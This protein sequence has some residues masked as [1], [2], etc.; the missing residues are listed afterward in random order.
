MSISDTSQ[1]L[2][3][4]LSADNTA[5]I[6]EAPRKFDLMAL[7]RDR[8]F[9]MVM[10]VLAASVYCFWPLFGT[11]IAHR[12][13]DME[14][15]YAHGFLIPFCAAYLIWD[16]WDRI[17]TIP[18]KPFWPAIVLLLPV[19]WVSYV[20]SR[21]IMPTLLSGLFLAV[22]IIGSLVVAGWRWMLALAPAN[23]FLFFFGMP[24][25]D[26][27]IDKFTMPLQI[28]STSIAYHSLDLS[29]FKPMRMDNTTI[30]VPNFSQPLTIAAAC[31][32]LRT[33]I[34]ILAA[35]IFFILIARLSWW[36]NLILAAI[37][38][39]LSMVVNGIRIALIGVAC[40]SMPQWAGDN[41]KQMHDMSGYV[42]LLLCFLALGWITKKMGYK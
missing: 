4:P 36:K 24:I 7:V 35:V 18:V 37:A 29:G 11:E 26:K 20:A 14:G 23:L 9:Q 6:E 1:P 22:L 34:A 31:S 17:K 10:A 13:M 25:L 5:A 42:A 30:F 15:Y 33:T 28:M 32:G 3:A 12:W 27:V 21:C 38:V 2:G 41:F 19:L 40:D 8:T 39:P 16:K